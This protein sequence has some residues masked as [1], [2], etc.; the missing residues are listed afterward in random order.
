MDKLFNFQSILLHTINALILFAVLYFLLYKPV[1]KFLK[2]R[3][4]RIEEQLQSARDT[5]E[6]ANTEYAAAKDKLRGAD[7][8][9]AATVSKGAQQAQARAQ[10]II[11]T[12]N[13]EAAR[14]IEKAQREANNILH[15]AREAMTDEAASLG[16]QIAAKVLSREVSESDHR[17]MID[18]FLKRVG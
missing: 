5:Q 18:D 15:N 4:A 9:V 14:I 8:E 16:V 11:A 6:Q 2:A 13:E 1:R 10:E 12:A 3:Q 17:Q 7:A